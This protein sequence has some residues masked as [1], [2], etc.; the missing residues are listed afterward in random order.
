MVDVSEL[1]DNTDMAITLVSYEMG[2]RGLGPKLYGTFKGGSIEEY[3]DDSHTLTSV[4]ST[5][6][7][8]LRHIAIS[9]ASVHSIKGLPFK[10]SGLQDYSVLQ[11][12]W[13][14]MIPSAKE[15]I[16]NNQDI[17]KYNL[18][19]EF[20]M[21]FDHL[22]E[23]NWLIK[24]YRSLKLREN[25]ILF[26]MNF[27]NCLVRNNPKDGQK[28]IVLIDY[29]QF[30]YNYRGIDL[31]VH[32]FNRLVKYDD[33]DCK[34][35]NG[36]TLPTDEERRRFLSIYQQE[37]KRLNE[38]FDGNGLDSIENL[39]IESIVGQCNYCLFCSVIVMAKAK[40]FIGS[41]PAFAPILEFMMRHFLLFKEQLEQLTNC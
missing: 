6:D 25:Y 30:Q 23:A 34:I 10:K 29:D 16:C 41:D 39:V 19:M 5:D 15:Y 37:I 22:K 1:G 2:R 17:K 38:D 18:D 9:L 20:I 7:D 28:K 32:F 33:K 8:V 31:G 35:I 14:K 11:M 36:A 26:D 12:E 40:M 3:I 4:E 24:K 21:T 27:L 13:I